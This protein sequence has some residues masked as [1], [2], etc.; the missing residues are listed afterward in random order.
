MKYSLI[1]TPSNFSTGDF[2]GFKNIFLK[3]LIK[4]FFLYFKLIYF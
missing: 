2:L 1:F 3:I 4:F